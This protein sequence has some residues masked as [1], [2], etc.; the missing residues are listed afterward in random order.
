MAQFDGTGVQVREMCFLAS[1]FALQTAESGSIT[2]FTRRATRAHSGNAV[3]TAEKRP[4]YNM[5]G[6]HARSEYIE[7]YEDQKH[8]DV[9]HTAFDHNR[10]CV[11]DEVVF[12]S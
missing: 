5:V 10:V 6:V 2:R 7:T 9:V 1:N 11:L 12:N 4:A 8:I 3:S